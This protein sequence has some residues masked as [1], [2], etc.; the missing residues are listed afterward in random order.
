M[1]QVDEIKEPT[2]RSDS[3]RISASPGDLAMLIGRLKRRLREQSSRQELTACLRCQHSS[4]WRR[5]GPM[6]V[7]A[8]VRAVGM[9]TQSM[10]TIVSALRSGT[11]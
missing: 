3:G 9:R 7:T 4:A 2:T 6:T 8:L 10:G 11:S 5:D 1:C